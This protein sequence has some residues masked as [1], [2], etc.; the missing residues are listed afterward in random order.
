MNR[1]ILIKNITIIEKFADWLREKSIYDD[2]DYCNIDD[3]LDDDDEEEED[4]ADRLYRIVKNMEKELE[5]CNN[6]LLEKYKN[7]F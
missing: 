6:K 3:L 7:K 4:V 5:V 2:Y 1:D